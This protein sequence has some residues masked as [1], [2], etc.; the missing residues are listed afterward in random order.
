MGFNSAFKVLIHWGGWQQ[1]RRTSFVMKTSGNKLL[2]KAKTHKRKNVFGG[3]FG[4]M[5]ERANHVGSNFSNYSKYR[6]LLWSVG[7]H[8]TISPFNV[9]RAVQRDTF[10]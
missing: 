1:A 2:A 7:L 9:Y 10:L 8:P 4:P 6:E 5:S 3:R